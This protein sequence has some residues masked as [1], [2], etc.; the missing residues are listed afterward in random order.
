MKYT[1]SLK[2]I[3]LRPRR[4]GIFQLYLGQQYPNKRANKWATTYNKDI[5]KSIVLF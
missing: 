5:K 1:P 3:K 2:L 4:H